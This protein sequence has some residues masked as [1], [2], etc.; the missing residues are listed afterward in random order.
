M[1]GVRINRSRR[2][3]AR[4]FAFGG[5]AALFTARTAGW[6][7]ASAPRPAPPA[8]D[9]RYWAEVRGGFVMP[10]GFA[11]LNAANLCPS[12]ARVIEAYF[13][14]TRSVDRDP[15]PQNRQKT[16]Q[17]REAARRALA[18]CLRVTPE[19]IVITRNTSES[20]NFV[21]S[22]LDL[23]AGDEVLIFSDNHPSNHAAWRQKAERF[24][25]VI[26]TVEQV[27]PH[28]GAEY[29]VDAFRRQLT[30]RTKVV[31]F[32]HVTASVGDLMPARELCALAREHGALSLVDGAQSFGVLDVN[33]GEMQP[34]FFSGSAHKWPC[35][36]KESGVLFVSRRA[37]DRIKP[38][39]VS[40]YQG[41]VGISRIMEAF[42]QRDEPAIVGFGEALA[43]QTTIGRAAI[44]QRARELSQTLIDGLRKIEGVK[45]WT[46]AD[47]GRSAAIVSF[48]PA[49]LDVRK[50]HQ[51]L[52]E[53]DRI[54]CA[55]RA[56]SD[57]GGIRFSPHFYNLRS[58]AVR[59]IDAV[60]KYVSRGL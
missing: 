15:S 37:H 38:S 20:N 19:E 32:T 49:G 4:L 28:P 21:S 55:T 16:R 12:P 30:A 58:D 53:Q 59:A 6:Q 57:R 54:A 1:T 51:A 18:S 25:F 36:P 13:D 52:Y 48:Q 7:A 44:E 41:E 27:N 29:Y 23:Q 34:D 45:V 17:G 9:E 22:G 8:A 40:L 24:G 50:L 43:L 10:E 56:G 42:G 26:R 5:S 39:I 11:C 35:G 47:P 2:D 3:F 14:S 33:L 60:R 31:A 46:H